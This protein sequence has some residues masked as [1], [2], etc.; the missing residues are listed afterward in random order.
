LPWLL[1]CALPREGTLRR[2]QLPFITTGIP[3]SHC[4]QEAG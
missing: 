3:N 2:T 4:I 1:Q